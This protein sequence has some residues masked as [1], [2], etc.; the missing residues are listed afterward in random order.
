[1]RDIRFPSIEC[2]LDNLIARLDKQASA[3]EWFIETKWEYD[4]VSNKDLF[5][6]CNMK[7]GSNDEASSSKLHLRL[8]HSRMQ[9]EKGEVTRLSQET[10]DGTTLTDQQ[11]QRLKELTAN[12]PPPKRTG[13]QI[14]LNV[15]DNLKLSKHECEGESTI[16]M[17]VGNTNTVNTYQGS[18]S[19]D[20]KTIYQNFVIT[21]IIF[22]KKPVVLPEILQ[23]KRSAP[24]DKP[25]SVANLTV[26]YQ[27]H[28]GSWRECQDVVIAPI[29]VRNE[30]PKWLTDSIIN[31]QPDKLVS[32]TIKGWIPAKG[33]VGYDNKA[34]KRVHR[35]LPQPLKLKIVVTDNYARQCSLVVEQLN[36]PLELIT[37]ESFLKDNHSSINELLAFVYADDCEN[38]GRIFMVIYLDKDNAL[39]IKNPGSFSAIFQ[40]TA[41]RTMEYNAK[42]NGTT[43]VEL[44]QMHYQYWSDECKA[45]ALF[46]PETYMIYAIRLELTTK[47]SRVEEIV[48]IP[49]EKIQT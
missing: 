14:N 37:H 3:A 33:Q 11:R 48:P 7:V 27:I 17:S 46:D 39:L 34:R 16:R 35:S 10:N 19:S 5:V 47:T 38:D 28:D 43:E 23:Q 45:F 26:F 21:H 44:E 32:F 8:D 31:I 9:I 30:E 42:R 12:I 41:L 2:I 49:I 13:P 6:V 29:A 20:D 22:S 18:Q 40:R 24:A 1:M 15:N 4:T 25:V 36:K